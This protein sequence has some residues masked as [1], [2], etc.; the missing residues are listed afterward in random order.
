MAITKA[1]K[2]NATQP[3]AQGQPEVSV[4]P[5]DAAVATPVSSVGTLDR[6]AE[7]IREFRR[8][9]VGDLLPHPGNNK[10]HGG[11]QLAA[12]SGLLSRYGKVDA[13]LA[14]P[15]DG[16]GPAGDFGTLMLW[17]GHG[18]QTIHPDET[19]C[20]AVTDLT[21]AE[22]KRNCC[23]TGQ[24]VPRAVAVRRSASGGFVAVKRY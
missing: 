9:R 17:D 18:R 13:L 7:R 1:T 15:A 2:Y 14:F 11:D 16:L 21:R 20:V 19:W 12:I 3:D 22:A 10:L 23:F 8:M 5:Q 24:M 4:S 6:F